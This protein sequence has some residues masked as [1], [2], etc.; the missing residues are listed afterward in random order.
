V[1]NVVAYGG[2]WM[3]VHTVKSDL[4]FDCCYSKLFPARD[5]PVE[6]TV[7]LVLTYAADAADKLSSYPLS[8]KLSVMVLNVLAVILTKSNCF[9]MLVD[10]PSKKHASYSRMYSLKVVPHK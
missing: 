1:G 8:I 5:F 3:A 4:V 2:V 7:T 10:I 6:L 9:F